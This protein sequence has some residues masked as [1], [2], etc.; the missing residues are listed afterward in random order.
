ML[1][2]DTLSC[3]ASLTFLPTPE[4]AH[5]FVSTW[6]PGVHELR[7]RIIGNYLAYDSQQLG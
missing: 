4:D 2:Y 7:A 5:Q 6:V 1:Y 3:A